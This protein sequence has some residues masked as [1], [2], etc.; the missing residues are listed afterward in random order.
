M[1]DHIIN[2]NSFLLMGKPSSRRRKWFNQR[3]LDTLAGAVKGV[4]IGGVLGNLPGAVIGGVI[5][6]KNAYKAAD[7]PH[8]NLPQN[9]TTMSPS[10]PVTRRVLRTPGSGR[11]RTSSI[12]SRSSSYRTSASVRGA[13]LRARR[14]R[15]RVAKRKF[16]KFKKRLRKKTRFMRKKLRKKS[17]KDMSKMLGYQVKVE[18]Y[19]TV[20][21]AFDIGIKHS[22]VFEDLT[23]STIMGA[24]VRKL[25]KKAGYQIAD[26]DQVLSGRGLAAKDASCWRLIFAVMDLPSSS[27][28]LSGSPYDLP[29]TASIQSIC[30]SAGFAD[31]YNYLRSFF[32]NSDDG[33][34]YQ[35][36]LQALDKNTGGTDTYVTRSELF[37]Q[38][39]TLHINSSSTLKIQNRSIGAT[40]GG[41]TSIAVDQQPLTGKLFTFRGGDPR[42]RYNQP[43]PGTPYAL[44]NTISGIPVTGL[45]PVNMSNLYG[46][47]GTTPK[48]GAWTTVPVKDKFQNCISAKPFK[49][50]SGETEQCHI[51]KS[52]SGKFQ[53]LLPKLRGLRNDDSR[54]QVVPGRSQMLICEELIRT[55][56]GNPVL[57]GYERS[58]TIGAWLTTSKKTI[59]FGTAFLSVAQS[60][61]G[62]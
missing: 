49:I 27:I 35:L 31:M 39:E 22:T 18:Q 5:G 36:V 32:R 9:S 4:A 33:V 21:D 48:Q 8:K 20:S 62:P 16:N 2:K 19:G 15:Y 43:A 58:V 59:S 41:T 23:V 17:K 14:S 13:R 47:P 50:A 12:F 60:A 6:A 1:K 44:D 3:P 56:S 54:Y 38:D 46:I 29:A 40:T 61:V 37:L 53:A 25:F 28:S 34:P 11:S 45:E 52:W 24:M 51:Q 55:P 57:V 30:S 7:G 10:T 26:H 42:L